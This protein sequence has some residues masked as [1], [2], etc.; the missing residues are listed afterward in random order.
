[1]DSL[2]VILNFISTKIRKAAEGIWTVFPELASLPLPPGKNEERLSQDLHGQC[3]GYV[4]TSCSI[5]IR[6][7]KWS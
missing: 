7:S 3:L 4:L 6:V 5:H 2:S 1:M